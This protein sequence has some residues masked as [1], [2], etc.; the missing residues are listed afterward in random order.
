MILRRLFASLERASAGAPGSTTA[1]GLSRRPS[2]EQDDLPEPAEQEVLG[3]GHRLRDADEHALVALERGRRGDREG[4]VGRGDGVGRPA[5]DDGGGGDLGLA[6]ELGGRA[7]DLDALSPFATLFALPL[8]TKM[9]SDV[10]ASPSPTA[11]WR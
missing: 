5:R 10:A 1:V 2:A 6:L 7:G 4:D 11:S 9:P 3:D 8:K